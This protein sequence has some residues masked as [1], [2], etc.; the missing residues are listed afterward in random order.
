[1]RHLFFISQTYSLD[2]LRPLQHA[3]WAR[4][5]D[6]KWFM[7]DL[8]TTHLQSNE[9]A[10]LT[11]REVN[12][13]QPDAVYAPGNVVPDF[14]PGLKVQ[15]FHGLA[16]DETGKKGHY[17]IR[18]FFDLYCTHGPVTTER[19]SVLAQE[20]GHFRAIETGWPK[21]DPL[22]NDT[23]L[24]NYKNR[25]PK[26]DKPLVL[27]ASTFSPR[28]TAA[29]A[30]LETLTQLTQSDEWNW[31]LTLHPKMPQPIVDAYQ[32]LANEHTIYVDSADDMLPLLASADVMLCDTSSILLEFMLLNKPVVTFNNAAP[33]A[34]LLNVTH[35]DDIHTALTHALQRP[36]EQM[37]A[38]QQYTQRIHP[39]RDGKSSERILDCVEDALK[40]GWPEELSAKPFNLLRKW[41]LRRAMQ[42]FGW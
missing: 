18:G 1:M 6:V 22:L 36:A 37:Q 42:Y 41:K 20:H 35:P 4:G 17:R 9:E 34:S 8:P 12:A 15:V 39:S 25:F 28:L 21:L 19:F 3:A 11:V 16:S 32:Q 27:F 26:T 13:Y 31:L 10:L 14:F 23:P 7:H 40:T 2:I 33:D 24:E 30:L 29:P 5:H 38:A